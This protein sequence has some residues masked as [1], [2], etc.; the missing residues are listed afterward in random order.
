MTLRLY[1]PAMM[2]SKTVRSSLAELKATRAQY[3]QALKSIDAAIVALQRVTEYPGPSPGH[4]KPA[5]VD[6]EIVESPRPHRGKSRRRGYR[7]AIARVLRRISPEGLSV[8][9]IIEAL[10]AEGKRVKG[11]DPY[12]TLYRVMRNSTEFRN[13]GGKW[14][15]AEKS[16]DLSAAGSKSPVHAASG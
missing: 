2:T 11:K 4:T 7:S 14:T 10:Q 15:V 6:A 5:R 3:A 16:D 12:K 8:R 1:L 9:Q 13:R